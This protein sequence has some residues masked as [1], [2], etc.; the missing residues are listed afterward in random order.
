MK[1][2]LKI[3][4]WI[5]IVVAILFLGFGI[6]VTLDVMHEEKGVFCVQSKRIESYIVKDSTFRD[7]IYILTIDNKD[8]TILNNYTLNIY[9]QIQIDS[10]YNVAINK[11]G[12][13]WIFDNNNI[14][15]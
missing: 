12:G 4:E 8:Y 13:I 14:K 7:Y 11:Y 6:K 5:V 3:S 1:D 15:K 2:V 10:C 9:N